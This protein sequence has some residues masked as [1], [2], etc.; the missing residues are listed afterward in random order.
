MRRQRGELRLVA[1]AEALLLVDHG[2]AEL[3]E[4]QPGQ[5]LR[6]DQD[7]DLA[8]PDRIPQR[9]RCRGRRDQPLDT[10]PRPFE[11]GPEHLQMLPRQ[12]RRRRGDRNLPA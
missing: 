4:A 12:H 6:P 11:P 5:A 3:G 2:Q 7:V 1:L 10:D 8:P 9:G